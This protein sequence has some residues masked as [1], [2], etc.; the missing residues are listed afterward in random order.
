MNRVYLSIVMLVCCLVCSVFLISTVSAQSPSECPTCNSSYPISCICP[1]IRPNV[2]Y[3]VSC[4]CPFS[5]LNNSSSLCC[6]CP[7]GPSCTQT[8][9]FQT[10]YLTV[11][12]SAN[13]TSGTAPLSIQFSDRSTG[14]PN[15]W[16]WDFG[17]GGTS[18]VQNP[19]Y[20]Y[21][22]PGTYAVSLTVTRV[23]GGSTGSVSESRSITKTGFIAVTGNQAGV[24]DN[25][26]LE[27]TSDNG[28]SPLIESR[29][30]EINRL[31]TTSNPT[32]SYL[33][34]IRSR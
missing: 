3:P 22:N 28:I 30:D 17:D 29:K 27:P 23:Y 34:S 15:R 12:F 11:D 4:I 21:K 9:R 16:L 2:T 32:T 31:L 5:N 26:G 19:V 20:I 25:P 1:L 7:F 33:S 14:N 24:Q 13:T 8:S 18:T 10:R 6:S